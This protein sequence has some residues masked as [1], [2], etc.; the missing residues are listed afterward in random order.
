MFKIEDTHPRRI[1]V[2]DRIE[3]SVVVKNECKC[4]RNPKQRK[5]RTFV[6]R[7]ILLR[8]R[9]RRWGDRRLFL[10]GA[11]RK[12]KSNS[13]GLS[14][15][16]GDNRDNVKTSNSNRARMRFGLAVRRLWSYFFHG[17]PESTSTGRTM[18]DGN[19]DLFPPTSGKIRRRL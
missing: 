14:D 7:N 10:Y 16:R 13:S 11:P 17:T 18:G 8:R 15:Y 4:P 2:H 6:N 1:I 3:N 12:D 9:T 5:N 19:C